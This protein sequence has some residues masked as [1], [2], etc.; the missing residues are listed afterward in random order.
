M[1]ILLIFLRSSILKLKIDE[2]TLFPKRENIYKTIYSPPICKQEM[3]LYTVIVLSVHG[4]L[5]T[6]LD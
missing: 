4:M 5:L 1:Y 2:D 6:R 3:I